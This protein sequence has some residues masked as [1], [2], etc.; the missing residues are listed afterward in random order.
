MEMPRG[1]E[2]GMEL[3]YRPA[4][5]GEGAAREF[6]AIL[7]KSRWPSRAARHDMTDREKCE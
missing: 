2:A 4:H 5:D 7:S 3:L 1:P 6:T